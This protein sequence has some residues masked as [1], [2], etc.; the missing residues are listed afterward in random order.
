MPKNFWK[1]ILSW[2]KIFT[3]SINKNQSDNPFWNKKFSKKKVFWPL[4][5]F[6]SLERF[7]SLRLN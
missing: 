5:D 1:G 3:E 6:G 2:K 4:L 7:W